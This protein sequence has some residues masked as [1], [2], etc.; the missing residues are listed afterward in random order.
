MSLN[1]SLESVG[2][3][4]PLSPNHRLSPAAHRRRGTKISAIVLFLLAALLKQTVFADAAANTSQPKFNFDCTRT[5]IWD[6]DIGCG[7]GKHVT[8]AGFNIGAGLG[9]RV[10]GSEERHD[11]VLGDVHIGTMLTGVVAKD[12]SG[13]EIGN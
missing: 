2:E 3:S 13:G 7:F 9:F 5:N 12:H 11:L 10:F 6:G 8:E 4:A 1:A